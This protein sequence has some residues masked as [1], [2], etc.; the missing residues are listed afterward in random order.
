MDFF[1]H[2]PSITTKVSVEFVDNY[3]LKF[4][5]FDRVSIGSEDL[6]GI[7]PG[8][9]SN[10]AINITPEP[11]HPA[12]PPTGLAFWVAP[13]ERKVRQKPSPID[14]SMHD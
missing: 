5:F 10:L 4:V 1:Y 6:K 7:F 14:L 8:P 11:L 9:L 3:E 12:F 13:L 2:H